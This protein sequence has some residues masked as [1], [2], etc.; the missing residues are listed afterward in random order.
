MLNRGM[1]HG[2]GE[3]EVRG[4]EVRGSEVRGSEGRER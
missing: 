1:S 2:R 3:R 4:S